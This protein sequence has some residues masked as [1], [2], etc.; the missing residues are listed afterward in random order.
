MGGVKNLLMPQLERR[1]YHARD[2]YV[3]GNCLDDYALAQVVEDNV[4]RTTCDFCGEERETAFA[5]SLLPVIEHIGKC[6]SQDYTHPANELP[7][8][9]REGGFQGTLIYPWDL[10]HDV[11]FVVES[12]DLLEEVVSAFSDQ[13]WCRRHYFSLSPEERWRHGWDDFKRVVKHQRRFTFWS[14]G[15]DKSALDAEHTPVGEMLGVIGEFVGKVSLSKPLPK[16]TE[17]WR[18]RP[19]STKTELSQ[20]HEL[21]PP[22][23]DVAWQ[24]NRMNPSGVVMFYGAEDF[25]TACLE[26]VDPDRTEGKKVTGA[27]FR[28]AREMRLLD[29]V[30][31]PE[32]PSYF[33]LPASER[34]IVLSFLHD[35]ARDLARPVA[36]DAHHHIEYVPTQAFTEYVRFELKPENGSSVDGIRYRSSVNGQPCYVLF[37]TQDECVADTPYGHERWLEFDST[38]LRTIHASEV[39]G[40]MGKHAMDDTA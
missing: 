35:F 37:C 36:R 4:E 12:E 38:S 3:C 19:H 21:S 28:T 14:I 31:L 25:E 1:G 27:I 24:A 6:I 32:I 20:D 29:L 5:A 2:R 17:I 33:D 7:Y 23:L 26:T 13:E 9:T 11:D 34:R 40:T 39:A 8:E 22:P 18:V 10:L 30:D 15:N 16:G